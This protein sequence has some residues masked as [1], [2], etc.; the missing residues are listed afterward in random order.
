MTKITLSVLMLLMIACSGTASA[1]NLWNDPDPLLTINDQEYQTEDYL[2]WWR[3]WREDNQLPSSPDAYIDWLLLSNEAE[4]MQLQDQP[5][6]QKKIQTF[7]KVRSM[8][9]LKKEEINDKVTKP[10]NETLHQYYLQ[11]YTPHWQ[12]QSVTFRNQTDLEQFIAAG[13]AAPDSSTEDILAGLA[14]A[15]SDYVLS[16]PVWER[17]NRLPAQILDILRET[18]NMRFSAPYPWKDTWQVIEILATE[19]ASDDEFTQLRNTLEQQHLKQQRTDLTAQLLQQL[20]K[21]FPVDINTE[22]LATIQDEELPEE[23]AQ[24]TVMEL[25]SHKITA[26]ELQSAAKK[27]YDSLSP[28][29]KMKT[30]FAQKLQQ[31]IGAI[32]SQNLVDAEALDR[33]YEQRP[34]FKSTF[35]FYRG[36]RLIR[37]LERQLIQPEVQ[38]VTPEAVKEA[39]EKYKVQLSGPVLVEIVRGET[40]DSDLAVQLHAHLRQGEDFSRIMAVLGHKNSKSEKLPLQHLSEPVQE[41]LNTL[42][43]GQAEMVAEAGNF[44]FI[45]LVKA[46]QQEIVAFDD[47]KDVLEGELKREAFLKRK[48][49]IVQQLRQRSTIVINQE[50]WQDCLDIL[51]KGS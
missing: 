25:L 40:K 35:D 11:N 4:Q 14:T 21:K 23:Q 5:S 46:P 37:E 16:S 47:I 32:I 27:Q 28:Q 20:K 43:P 34:P 12:L 44:I 7:L 41:V 45:Q 33:H 42:K 30:P 31:V 24:Q 26:A 10:D 38:S 39:Y 22:L 51:K 17:P 3:E 48:Q 9:L 19:Q 15:T 50:Q 36:H 13:A 6:Y 49:A 2:N 29:Q 1:W 8:M 18:Q